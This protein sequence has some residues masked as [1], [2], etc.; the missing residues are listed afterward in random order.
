MKKNLG[1]LGQTEIRKGISS[2]QALVDQ[3]GEGISKCAEQKSKNVVVIN[4]LTAENKK[5]DEDISKAVA[6][7]DQLKAIMQK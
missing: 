6:V 2:S 7:K 3:I 4:K 1:E 5:L